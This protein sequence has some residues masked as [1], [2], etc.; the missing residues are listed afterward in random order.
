MP[1]LP[2][3]CQA[4]GCPGYAKI[5]F[6]LVPLNAPWI[7][8][9]SSRDFRQLSIQDPKPQAPSN[10]LSLVQHPSPVQCPSAALV[11]SVHSALSINKPLVPLSCS[12]VCNN[13]LAS[14]PCLTSAHS[15][16]SFLFLHNKILQKQYT[17]FQVLSDHCTKITS[18]VVQKRHHNLFFLMQKGQAD[19]SGNCP[20]GTV[21]DTGIV[22]PF[23]FDFTSSSK[24]V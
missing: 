21:V 8:D 13:S 2:Q 17:F 5:G 19:R 14:V 15:S 20:P 18:V 10:V 3:G 12:P 6:V 16:Y 1:L 9:I 24:R 22:H 4:P 7:S 11:P 23:Q